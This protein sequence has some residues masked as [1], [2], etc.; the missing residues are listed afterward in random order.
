MPKGNKNDRVDDQFKT[1]QDHIGVGRKGNTSLDEGGLYQNKFSGMHN[2]TVDKP[3][4]MLVS[5]E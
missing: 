2:E 4:L 3:E 5:E 1:F